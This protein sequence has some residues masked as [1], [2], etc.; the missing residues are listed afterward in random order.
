MTAAKSVVYQLTRPRRFCAV[1][2]CPVEITSLDPGRPRKLCKR[3]AAEARRERNR[4]E[5][6]RAYA[7]KK[8]V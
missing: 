4:A 8:A 2:G 6:R 7:K 3:H 1:S 5:C